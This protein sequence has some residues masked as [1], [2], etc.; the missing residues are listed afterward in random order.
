MKTL[1]NV[2]AL[3][4]WGILTSTYKKQV[5]FLFFKQERNFTLR[6]IS[7]GCSCLFWVQSK[8][9]LEQT[10][11]TPIGVYRNWTTAM[12]SKRHNPESLVLKARK[13]LSV[14]WLTRYLHD[15]YV[16]KGPNF[17]SSLWK[18]HWLHHIT[19]AKKSSHSTTEDFT[20]K[21]C[22]DRKLRT[23]GQ[24]CFSLNIFC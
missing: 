17:F 6:S 15:R 19:F 23:L 18:C 8:Q 14:S 24:N 21:S 2:Y 3:L 22:Q 1:L 12:G 4:L 9:L 10:A 11:R 7:P 20:R 13:A 16:L 5:D